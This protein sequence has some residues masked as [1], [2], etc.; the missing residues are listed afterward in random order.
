MQRR[1][2]PGLVADADATEAAEGGRV[3]EVEGQFLVAEALHLLEH[4]DADDLVAGESHP[5]AAGVGSGR[6]QVLHGE[7]RGRR[8][9]VED[10]TD[11]LQLL[12]VRMVH[13]G[14][15]E[16]ELMLMVS[17]HRGRSRLRLYGRD[18][19]GSCRDQ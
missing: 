18:C 10:I 4:T 9:G 7:R 5:A 19:L 2:S 12:G 1:G 14:R 3:A 6:E 17:A 11:D 8:D 16:P 15:G 13:L